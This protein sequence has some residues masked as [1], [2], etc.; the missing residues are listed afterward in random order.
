ML[1]IAFI[2]VFTFALVAVVIQYLIDSAAVCSRMSALEAKVKRIEA[3]LDIL[4]TLNGLR[5]R[6]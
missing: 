1:I 6:F 5:D 3:E 4:D 2:A